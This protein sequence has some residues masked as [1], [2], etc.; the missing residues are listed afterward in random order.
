MRFF[1]LRF[2]LANYLFGPDS[3]TN[4][5]FAR[6]KDDAVIRVSRQENICN[7]FPAR[8]SNPISGI[9][10]GKAILPHPSVLREMK[11][12]KA[13]RTENSPWNNQI[14]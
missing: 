14:S 8:C 11:H 12:K 6:K 4:A 7:T 10:G 1:F 13:M 9:L 2:R 3:K 5:R